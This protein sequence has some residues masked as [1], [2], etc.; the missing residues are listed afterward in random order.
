MAGQ[1]RLPA[2]P[3]EAWLHAPPHRLDPAPLSLRQPAPDAEPLVVTEGI[4]EA[5][6]A[7]LAAAAHP[8]G[9]AGRAALLREERLRIGLRAQRPVLPALLPGIVCADPKLAHQRDDDICHG[10]PPAVWSP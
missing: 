10:A 9:L 1:F 7:H 6:R 8:L 4:L 2:T 3:S 5:L